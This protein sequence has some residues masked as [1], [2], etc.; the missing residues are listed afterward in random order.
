M[1]LVL[2]KAEADP[3]AKA[4]ATEKFY[5]SIARKKIIGFSP[6]VTLIC[7]SCSKSKVYLTYSK[8]YCTPKLKE[9]FGRL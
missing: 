4:K 3:K 8:V 1:N 9:R 5:Q 7:N 6:A 2:S